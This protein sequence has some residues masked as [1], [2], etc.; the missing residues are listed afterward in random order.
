MRRVLKW[1]ASLLL[2]TYSVGRAE[3][4]E[5]VAGAMIYA[6]VRE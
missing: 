2:M 3:E 1:L 5:W 4:R 6:T